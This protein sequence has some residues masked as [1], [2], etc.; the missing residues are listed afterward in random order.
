[1]QMNPVVTSGGRRTF[2]WSSVARELVNANPKISGYP[3]RLMITQLV[4]LTGNPRSACRRFVRRMG[5][6]AKNNYKRW[7]VSEQQRLLEMLDNYCVSEA[8]GRMRCSESA[9]Y[10]MLRRLQ[11]R[12]SMR[13]DCISKTHLAAALHVHIY[14][15][16]N[17]IA[18][19]KLKA[20]VVQ[21]G[22]V[23][24]T[25]IQPNDF[26]QFCQEH[27]EAVIGNRLNVERLEFVYKYLFPPDHNCLLS[28]REH[29][30]ERAASVA[31]TLPNAEEKQTE[32]DC[33]Q[34]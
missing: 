6:K 5:N 17:W 30:K 32:A 27:R 28:V 33:E 31:A 3:L 11:L 24:R 9:I 29:K 34:P 1:M 8:A 22:K 10:G 26:H 25:M 20:T 15:V 4:R 16:G 14:E 18:S 2:K 21:R 19:G 12:A 7:P 23:S 13:Q